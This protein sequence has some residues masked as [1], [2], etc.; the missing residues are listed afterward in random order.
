MVMVADFKEIKK[1]DI[2]IAGGKGANLGEMTRL[3]IN[4]PPGFIITAKAYREFLRVNGIEDII[5]NR[6]YKTENDENALLNAADDFRKRINSGIFPDAL[7]ELIREKYLSLGENKKVAIR[8]SATAEDLKD[9]SF[10]GQQD[11]Y[12]NIQG[13]EEILKHIRNCY[14]SLWTKRAV[15][16]RYHQGYDQNRVSIAVVVQEMVES[17]KSGVLFTAD[18]INNNKNNIL[19]NAAFGLGESVVSGRVSADTYTVDKRTKESKINIGNKE[20]QIIYG[21]KG[22]VEEALSDEKRKSRVLNDREISQLLEYGIKIEKHYKMPM[23]I[24]WAIKDG[25]VYIL[26]ARAVTTLNKKNIDTNEERIVLPYIKGKKIGKS[27]GKVLSFL[28]EKMPFAY[29]A[30]DFCYLEAINDQKANILS[31]GGIVMPKNPQIDDDGIQTLSSAKMRFDKNIINFFKV[32]KTVTD[33]DYCYDKCID[34]MKRYES[35]TERIKAIDFEDM[36]LVKCKE[37]IK[38]SYES[39]RSLAYDR[40]K[41]ALFPSVLM[42]KKLDR[43]IK[44]ADPT[45]S[46]FDF[47]LGL[48]NKTSVVSEDISAL[49]HGIRKN[50]ELKK[51]IIKGESYHKLY[52]NYDEFRLSVNRFMKVNGYKSDYNCYC[53]SAR[54]FI[55]DPDRLLNI[56]IPILKS[57][58][59]EVSRKN[60]K[61][62]SKIMQSL[63]NIY[64]KKFGIIEKQINRY[65]YFHVVREETQYL[66]E[67]LFFCIRRCVKRI[68]LILIGNEDY[69][70]GVANLFY[71]ELLEVLERGMLTEEYK[72]KIHRRNDKFPLALKVWEA[73]KTLIFKGGGKILKGVSASSGIAVGRAC[74]INGSGEFYKMKKGDI[75]V[76]HY[77]DPE[78]TPLF[79]LAAAVVADTGSELSH[80]AIVAREYNIPAVLGVGLASSVFKDGDRIQVDGNKGMVK[81]M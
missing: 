1:E 2:L 9:A 57:E 23:D 39:V 66:W 70:S 76:C 33:L 44:K 13:M 11:S 77:T 12:L 5:N 43:I 35:E 6:L 73:S 31:E 47:L 16:Y 65:R 51:S 79:A 20:T 81:G 54:T 62:F 49:A 8:S 21:E 37:F 68:N 46:S 64:G 10:A 56:L 67:T 53:L 69:D 17:E 24:E 3:D 7:K 55:E 80:A 27:T 18:P 41:Y 40:F 58:E 59:E 45:Y 78:W 29:R 25:I 19:I 34:F 48:N 38:D 4:V 52:E 63:E 71:K 60:S 32:L 75:L 22:T 74:I 42:S 28:L 61:D 50:V 36:P 15:S 30:L 72:E 26:Q 14:A